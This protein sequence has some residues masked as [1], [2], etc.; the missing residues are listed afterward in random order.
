MAKITKF[1]QD[2]GNSGLDL[3]LDF[4][5]KGFYGENSFQL[6]AGDIIFL[7]YTNGCIWNMLG[8]KRK[9]LYQSSQ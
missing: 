3:F 5:H 7:H 4:D 6:P 8:V 2:N 9:D 1:G